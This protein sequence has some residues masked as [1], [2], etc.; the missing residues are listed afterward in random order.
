MDKVLADTL[1]ANLKSATT[2]ESRQQAQ[3]L[4][5]IAVVDCQFKTSERVKK[6]VEDKEAETNRKIGAKIAVASIVG[7]ASVVGPVIAIKICKV[8]GVLW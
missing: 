3:T 4:A 6:L 5:M 2:P 8:V 7:L 1:K